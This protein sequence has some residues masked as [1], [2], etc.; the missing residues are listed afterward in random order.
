MYL[1]KKNHMSKCQHQ[2]NHLNFGVHLFLTTVEKK[3]LTELL[4]QQNLVVG[5]II[6]TINNSFLNF[7]KFICCLALVI[8]YINVYL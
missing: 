1:F 8:I 3:A 7:I 6:K 2:Q 5:K 4:S